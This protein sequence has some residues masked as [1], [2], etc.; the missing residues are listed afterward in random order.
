ME[1]IGFINHRF[2]ILTQQN[3]FPYEYKHLKL[4]H[5]I[6][7]I[8]SLLTLNQ[9]IV[10][11]GIV[12]VNGRLAQ[13]PSLTYNERYPELLHHNSKLSQ[14]LVEFTHKVT[15][16]GENQLM[17]RVLRAEYWIFRLKTLGR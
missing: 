14:L 8:S 13:S 3:H 7:P 10:R 5:K 11:H 17:I 15:L 2:I 16:H 12:R 1:E 6:S 9:F 4:K